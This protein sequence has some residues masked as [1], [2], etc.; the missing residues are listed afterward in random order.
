LNRA[1]RSDQVLSQKDQEWADAMSSAINGAPASMRYEGEAYRGFRLAKAELDRIIETREFHEPAFMSAT[2]HMGTA[3]SFAKSE[4]G[5]RVPVMLVVKC[6]GQGVDLSKIQKASAEGS[7][8]EVLFD[9]GAHF[10]VLDVV[11]PGEKAPWHKLAV[12]LVSRQATLS[13]ER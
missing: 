7:E 11:P 1:L 2:Q 3:I 10:K 6:N 4:E 8:S 5:G 12:E 9:R 13:A